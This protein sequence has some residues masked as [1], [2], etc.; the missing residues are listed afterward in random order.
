[1]CSFPFSEVTLVPLLSVIS[2]TFIFFFYMKQTLQAPHA[3]Q[4]L[5]KN[6]PCWSFQKMELYV[7]FCFQLAELFCCLIASDFKI[8]AKPV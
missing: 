1:M 3:T 8:V 4:C 7:F 2:Q 6:V 5:Y